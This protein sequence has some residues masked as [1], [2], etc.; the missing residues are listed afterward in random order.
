MR[1]LFV[2]L[3]ICGAAGFS[4]PAFGGP[5]P[6]APPEIRLLPPFPVEGGESWPVEE[7]LR[8]YNVPGVSIAVV[9]GGR[10]VFAKGYGFA[11]VEKQRP[12]TTDTLFLAG[13]VSKPV[14][15]MA[16][17]DLVERGKLPLDADVNT[18]LRTWQ[19]PSNEL[20]AKT[21]VTLRHLFSHS[22]GTT[23]YGFPGYL[24]DEPLPTT[25]QVLEGTPPANTP[26]V[27]VDL[28]PNTK[29][30]YSGGGTTIAQLALA[31]TQRESFPSLMRRLVLEPLGM[32]AS[33]YENPLP[34]SKHARA[35]TG[36]RPAGRAVPGGWHVYPEMA[37]AGLWTNPSELARVVVEFGD[38]LAGRPS[39]VL[40]IDGA[41]LM[42]TPRFPTGSTTQVGIGFFLDDRGTFGH[43]GSDEGFI[44]RLVASKDGRHG[45]IIMANSDAS[46]PLL[47]EIE[48]GVARAYGWQGHL[49][50]LR[51]TLPV[52]EDLLNRAP[53]RYKQGPDR[54][55]SVRRGG[56]ALELR[57]VDG[58]WVKLY[59]H[60]DGTF[61]RT[62][63]DQR[64]RVTTEG[65]EVTTGM[66]TA[67]AP[68][69]TEPPA[70]SELIAEGRLDEGLAAY[71][72]SKPDTQTLNRLGG[73]YQRTGR[74]GEAVALFRLNTELYP[75]SANAWDN[76]ATAM[77]QV[78][79][80]AGAAEATRNA[81]ARVDADTTA[82]DTT[83][84]WIRIGGRMRLRE[85]AAQR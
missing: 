63:A 22:G 52:P 47:G 13:S 3:A 24:R 43:D 59:Y 41:R 51:A 48:R 21:P 67:P 81:L 15:A 83:K 85:M 55:L 10:V 57:T 61:T 23:V 40:S 69:T 4:P 17:I 56:D 46:G 37:A 60:A 5:E 33:T 39:R 12:V 6:A 2:V 45:V 19:L 75:D 72:A 65:L 64:F 62:D 36:Y 77:F 44:T 66:T 29:F 76:L 1:R 82:D 8:F 30:R 31:E 16:A 68:R 50:P 80:F 28:A 70:P 79:D 78:N 53:G 26:P 35:A 14:T 49:P 7:R 74:Y 58:R 18:L 20:T 38:A 71:R 34:P 73:S 54:I 84:F 27:R 25:R 11:D 9:D 32:R 42:L